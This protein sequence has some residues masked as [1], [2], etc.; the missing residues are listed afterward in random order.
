MKEVVLKNSKILFRNDGLVEVIFGHHA[1]IDLDDCYDIL[2]VYKQ[3]LT[4]KKTPILHVLGNYTNFTSEA[5]VYGAS[6][7][8]LSF[9]IAEA[10]LYNS[11]PHQIIGNFYLSINK[12]SVPTKFFKS[13]EE[14]E[15]WLKTFL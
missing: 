2:N 3:E 14:A 5:K 13:K 9:S 10:F 6:P 11:L 7:E 1:V 8:G 15:T 12:P 4:E